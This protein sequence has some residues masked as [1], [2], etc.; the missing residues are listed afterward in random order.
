MATK[1]EVMG[2]GMRRVHRSFAKIL[3]DDRFAYTLRGLIVGFDATCAP[4]PHPPAPRP[5]RFRFSRRRTEMFH[6]TYIDPD[7]EKEAAFDQ[8]ESRATVKQG[9]IA[10]RK[11]SPLPNDICR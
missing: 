10:Y 3:E 2:E 6:V 4:F 9:I 1:E 5:E 11:C 8:H 7:P